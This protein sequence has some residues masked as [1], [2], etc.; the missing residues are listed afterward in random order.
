MMTTPYDARRSMRIRE[1]SEKAYHLAHI[2]KDYPNHRKDGFEFGKSQLTR[3]EK[4]LSETA[5]LIVTMVDD[6]RK[7]IDTDTHYFEPKL[8]GQTGPELQ[9]ITPPL[10]VDEITAA[11]P[12]PATDPNKV[13]RVMEQTIPASLLERIASRKDCGD[14]MDCGD[15]D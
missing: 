15:C 8:V 10:T 11:F 3:I 13:A 9:R 14:G 7:Q 12:N 5:A 4:I 2:I 1:A 6:E